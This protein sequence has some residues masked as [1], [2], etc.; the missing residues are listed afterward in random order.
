MRRPDLD[1]S[2]GQCGTDSP[3]DGPID[4]SGSP[5][6]AEQI[7]PD[8]TVYLTIHFSTKVN[9]RA[10]VRGPQSDLSGVA[11]PAGLR[12]EHAPS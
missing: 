7:E 10:G 6:R 5:V 9:A 1:V 2:G 3:S 12:T 11:I 8:P 4:R